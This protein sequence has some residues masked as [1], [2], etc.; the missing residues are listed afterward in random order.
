MLGAL[1]ISRFGGLGSEDWALVAALR[2]VANCSESDQQIARLAATVRAFAVGHQG[3]SDAEAIL[4]IFRRL[5][6]RRL[7]AKK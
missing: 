5:V 7:K 1:G 6:E 4:L 3:F 2:H